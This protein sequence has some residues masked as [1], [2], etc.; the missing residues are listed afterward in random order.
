MSDEET[1]LVPERHAGRAGRMLLRLVLLGVRASLLFSP[2]PAARLV[3]RVFASTGA[4]FAQALARHAPAGVEALVD[5]RYG[6]EPDMR[7]DVY[8]PAAATGALPLLVWLHGGGFV[9]GAKEELAGYLKLIAHD[10]YVVAAPR[11]SLAPDRRYPTPPRQMMQAWDISR[12]DAERL[13]IDPDRIALAGDSAGAHI[14]AQLAALVTTP[15]YAD[16]VGVS[17]TITPARL[18]C[19]VLVCGPYDLGLA[20]HASSPAGSRFIQIVLWA[21]TGKRHFL[22]DPAASSWSVTENLTSAFPPALITVGNADPLKE[23]SELLARKLRDHGVETATPRT[24]SSRS[25]T[26][27]SSTSMP[28]LGSCSSNACS[29]SCNSISER[30]RKRSGTLVR[31]SSPPDAAA[32]PEPS[33]KHV[34]ARDPWLTSLLANLGHPSHRR[35][36]DVSAGIAFRGPHLASRSAGSCKRPRGASTD[37]GALLVA[38]RSNSGAGVGGVGVKAT[39]GPA[40]DGR[41]RPAFAVVRPSRRQLHMPCNARKGRSRH[42][43]GS[44]VARGGSRVCGS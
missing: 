10:G 11:Y 40:P 17:P 13:R 24:K 6:D 43:G 25:V 5:E 41:R 42:R 32:M 36:V 4:N 8:R 22:D 37:G 12:G 15:G 34:P 19:L 35:G 1:P 39:A 38:N 7:L 29:R 20:R 30:R 44:L 28:T 33:P 16:V 14:A 26:S 21:Y 3:R 9:G 23:H 18:R 27:T 2:R 31:F